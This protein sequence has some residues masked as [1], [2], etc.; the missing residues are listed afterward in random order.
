MGTYAQPIFGNGDY[1]ET[2]KQSVAVMSEKEGFAESVLMQL[3]KSDQ[4]YVK[5]AYDFLGLNYYETRYAAARRYGHGV[6]TWV[7]DAQTYI[8]G[9]SAIAASVPKVSR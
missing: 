3:S 4:K 5:S 9:S 6:F 2:V 1:P 8:L 7:A